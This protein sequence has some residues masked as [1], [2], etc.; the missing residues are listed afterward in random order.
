MPSA[1]SV[2]TE[3]ATSS[4]TV[5]VPTSRPKDSPTKV[6]KMTIAHTPKSAEGCGFSTAI[7]YDISKY[8][9]GK[10]ILDGADATVLARK[11][12]LK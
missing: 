5:S 8:K 1:T 6:T 9:V 12:A 11:Y 4:L 3:I 2:A 7:G 10:T